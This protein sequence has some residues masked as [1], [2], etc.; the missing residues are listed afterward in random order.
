MAAAVRASLPV[1]RAVTPAPGPRPEAGAGGLRAGDRLALR[2]GDRELNAYVETVV[3]DTLVPVAHAI[4]GR[5][6]S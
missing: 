1:R 2:V 4:A 6:G 5:K 3:V